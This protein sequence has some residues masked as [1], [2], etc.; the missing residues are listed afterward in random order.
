M[1]HRLIFFRKFAIPHIKKVP[2]RKLFDV[3]MFFCE[4]IIY[5]QY[6]LSALASGLL[7]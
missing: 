6:T 4:I 1:F 3:T 2:K 5:Y 7:P